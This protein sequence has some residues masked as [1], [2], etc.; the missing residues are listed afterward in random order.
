MQQTI[1][2]ERWEAIHNACL[3][4]VSRQ[5]NNA[6]QLTLEVEGKTFPV[7]A[8]IGTWIDVFEGKIG[9]LIRDGSGEPTF[10]P[11]ADQSLRRAPELDSIRPRKNSVGWRCDSRPA[12]TAPPGVIPGV[13]GCLHYDATEPVT[14]P[15][16]P[17]FFRLARQHQMTAQELLRGFIADVC[18]LESFTSC[19]RADGY[20]SNGSDERM[21]AQDWLER[22]YGHLRVDID[23]IEQREQI[24]DEGVEQLSDC[25]SD[26]LAA[27]G[28]ADELVEVVRQLVEAKQSE[29]EKSAENPAS[30]PAGDEP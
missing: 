9:C 1:S 29:Q 18:A 15:V 24:H 5:E 10:M 22:A 2:S 30:G 3:V 26:F 23:E 14:V 7:E 27:G 19:P 4:K 16:P 21:L 25:L 11:Y 8:R 28:A 13:D 6:V 20:S 17:E 12:F